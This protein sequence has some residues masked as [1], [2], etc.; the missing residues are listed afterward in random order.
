MTTYSSHIGNSSKLFLSCFIILAYYLIEEAFYASLDLKVL[1]WAN[2]FLRVITKEF[3]LSVK[4]MRMLG[5]LHEAL[6]DTEKARDIYSELIVA[7][8]SD[9]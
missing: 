2:A 6:Q 8:S 3:P 7:N 9:F 5:M 4:S 1:D